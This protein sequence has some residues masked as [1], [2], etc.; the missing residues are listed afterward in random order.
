[1]TDERPAD[2][3][4]AAADIADDVDAGAFI[5]SEAELTRPDI[6]A[7]SGDAPPAI[8]DSG[9]SPPP[10]GHREGDPA[11]DDEIKRKG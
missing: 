1:M 2:R 6:P 4:P 3:D 9:W 11:D 8:P 10:A 5:G 7:S